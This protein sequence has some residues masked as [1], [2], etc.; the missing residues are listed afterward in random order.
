[1]ER[2]YEVSIETNGAME[3]LLK[4]IKDKKMYLIRGMF[5]GE[6]IDIEVY[7][8]PHNIIP[9]SEDGCNPCESYLWEGHG[10]LEKSKFL[11]L[12]PNLMENLWDSPWVGFHVRNLIE[13]L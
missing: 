4:V 13:E 1:M 8:V 3:F 9:F 2:N 7:S 6:G 5:D 11:K 12:M 10:N